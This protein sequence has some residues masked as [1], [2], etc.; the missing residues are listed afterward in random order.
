MSEAS[1][2][3]TGMILAVEEAR[4]LYLR[5]PEHEL[6]GIWNDASNDD[7]WENFQVRF[8]KPGLAKEQRG[9][10]SGQA[11]F[12]GQYFLALQKANEPVNAANIISI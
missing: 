10:Q 7:L 5:E 2:A 8:G 6:L 3:A 1:E 11:Y 12:W 4:K 9:T